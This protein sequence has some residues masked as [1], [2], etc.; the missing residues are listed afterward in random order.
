MDK[1]RVVIYG[2]HQSA[3]E[4]VMQLKY[5]FDV[6]AYVDTGIKELPDN[7]VGWNGLPIYSEAAKLREVNFDFI[8]VI[9]SDF[10]SCK[11]ELCDLLG[12]NQ[13]KIIDMVSGH[14]P[15]KFKLF[16]CLANEIYRHN[17]K[18]AAVE[19]GVDRGDTAKYL[20]LF[21]NDRALYLFDTFEGFAQQDLEFERSFSP[22]SDGVAHAYHNRTTVNDVLSKMYF[23]E[24]C[25]VKKGIFPDS[26][27]GL[28]D[29]F[30][31]V[32]IDCDLAKPV[33][34]A[35]QYFYPRLSP[36][37]YICIHDYYNILFPLVR[38]VV[39]Q[40]SAALKGPYV[41]VPAFGGVV[42]CKPPN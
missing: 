40:F 17:V 20:N 7:A 28:E 27:D 16:L 35:I 5:V 29:T 32:H 15:G 19:L 10:T 26:L 25:V 1:Q 24:K 18:G 13:E 11:K 4:L 22:V 38:Q 31:F 3:Y 14:Q 6:V 21:F 9:A 34:A 12:V 42:F 8:F 30:S 23:R 41:P 39:R 36:G 33:M 2:P 37:G